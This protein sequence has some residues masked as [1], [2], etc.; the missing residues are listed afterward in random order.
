MRD[1]KT[2]AAIISQILFD[3]RDRFHIQMIG[4][5]IEEQQIGFRDDRAGKN[6]AAE[7]AAGK[8]RAFLFGI[9]DGKFPEDRF[10]FLFRIPRIVIGE[11]LFD[12]LVI[13]RID[14][15]GFEL[16]AQGFVPVQSLPDRLP[17]REF[18]MR[19]E[20]LGHVSNADIPCDA[21]LSG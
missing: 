15:E 18:G 19:L 7:F 3:P 13:G 10:E 2:R 21:D 9:C 8:F 17:D 1:E 12:F 16:F 4:R 11:D 20:G 6:D 5:L 14:R